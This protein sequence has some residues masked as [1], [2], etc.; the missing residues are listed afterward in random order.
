MAKIIRTDL[1]DER[2]LDDEEAD[3]IYN[4]LD[5]CVTHEVRGHSAPSMGEEAQLSYRF[6]LAMRGIALE[7]MLRGTLV[8]LDLRNQAIGALDRGIE[9]LESIRDRYALVTWGRQLNDGS[10][11]QLRAYFYEYMGLPEQYRND[12]GTRKVTTNRKALEELLK[13]YFYAEPMCR[14][15]LKL[16]DLR[17][18]RSTLLSAVDSDSRMRTSYNVGATENDR[19]SSSGN[20]F[21]TGT[22]DQNITD[23]VRRI[24]VSE[25]GRKFGNV[26]LEQA[27]SRVVAY[28]SGDPEYID[29]VESGDLHTT[30]TSMVWPFMFHRVAEDLY[31]DVADGLFYRHFS[32]RHVCKVLG[33][34]TNYYGQPWTAS[35]HTNIPIEM[36]EEFQETYLGRFTGIS[37]W[38]SR[39][40]EKLQLDGYLTTC[41]GWRRDFLGRRDDDATLREFIA[42]EPQSVVVQILNILMHRMRKAFSFSDLQMLKQGHD[43]FMF[44]YPE[45]LE[46]EI[47]SAVSELS[48]IPIPCNGR[49]FRIPAEISLGWNWGK[50]NDKK[51]KGPINLGGLR[52]PILGRD[53]RVRDRPAFTPLLDRKLHGVHRRITNQ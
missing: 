12:K 11:I 33:H 27:E 39:C 31:R 18:L 37:D 45:I 52:P 50:F 14:V 44:S 21:G 53:E 22:N 9:R 6:N 49:I 36:C 29:A 15:I 32:Y 4:G 20:A 48:D 25:E 28:V 34:L 30:V 23:E 35:Q 3:W 17:K 46:P 24:F 40:A 5:N 13:L 26:D 16:R 41:L 1:L 2:S 10:P 7:M 38:H 8:D 43:S 47:I 19:W 51:K 42:C